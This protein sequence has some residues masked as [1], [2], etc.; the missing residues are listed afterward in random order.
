MAML[1]GR[2]I[3][4]LHVSDDVELQQIRSKILQKYFAVT[5]CDTASVLKFL[6]TDDFDMVVFC[7]SVEPS[8]LSKIAKDILAASIPVEMAQLSDSATVPS[9]VSIPRF[10]VEKM[11]TMLQALG[12]HS[13]K[14]KTDSVR[15]SRT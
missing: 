9:V 15:S 14:H 10:E 1:G 11:L 5:N 13:H 3:R 7:G 4:I 12:A 8:K 6:T 2:N